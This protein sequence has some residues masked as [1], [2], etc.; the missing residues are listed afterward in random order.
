VAERE[1]HVVFGIFML[2][3][4]IHKPTLRSHFTTKTAISILGFGN[5]L[6]KNETNISISE[7]HQQ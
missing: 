4:I 2:I 3:G 6:R 5:V 7:L 1:I